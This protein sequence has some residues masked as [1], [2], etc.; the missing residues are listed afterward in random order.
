MA[1]LKER[2]FAVPDGEIHPR[3]FEAGEEVSGGVE[4]AALAEGKIAKPKPTK[5]KAKAMPAAPENKAVVDPTAP[6]PVEQLP[7]E[8][9]ETDEDDAA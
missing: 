1:K 8:P 9:S 4:A 7:V 3:W 5:A 6:Q 2:I